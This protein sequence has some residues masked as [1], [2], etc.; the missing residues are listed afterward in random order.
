MHGNKQTRRL[1][2]STMFRSIK[3]AANV[4]IDTKMVDCFSDSGDPASLKIIVEY[5]IIDIDPDRK[6]NIKDGNVMKIAFFA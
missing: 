6:L 5:E 2:R 3:F 1:N 4:V